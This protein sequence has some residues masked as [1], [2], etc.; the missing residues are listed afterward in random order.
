MIAQ[1][2]LECGLFQLS[3]VLYSL[4]HCAPL[5]YTFINPH[6]TCRAINHG[7]LFLQSHLEFSK[8][9]SSHCLLI[10]P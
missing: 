1:D 6:P 2:S 4:T 8:Q 9:N 3:R 10:S 5:A 7:Q